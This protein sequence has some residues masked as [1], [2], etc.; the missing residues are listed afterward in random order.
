LLLV[1]GPDLQLNIEFSSMPKEKKEEEPEK[2][3]RALTAFFYFAKEARVSLL[4]ERPEMKSSDNFGEIGREI[5]KK[6][7]RID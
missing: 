3:N 5:Q 6:M 7:G 4:N 1:I 2:P